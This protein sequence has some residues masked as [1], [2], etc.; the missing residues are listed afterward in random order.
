M[1]LDGARDRRTLELVEAKELW[2]TEN[3][4]KEGYVCYCW[5]TQVHPASYDKE[6]N[7]K[8]E[9]GCDMG[10]SES[11]LRVRINRRLSRPKASRCCSRAS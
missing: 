1:A 6:K 10:G 3:V 9:S 5:L 2:A 11:S 7:I 8:L 4:D